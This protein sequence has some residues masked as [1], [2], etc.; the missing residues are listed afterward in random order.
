MFLFCIYFPIVCSFH[1]LNLSFSHAR[2]HVQLSV[3]NMVII[4]PCRA[5]SCLTAAHQTGFQMSGRGRRKKKG[6]THAQLLTCSTFPEQR[7]AQRLLL[8][9]QLHTNSALCWFHLIKPTRSL[10]LMDASRETFIF[11]N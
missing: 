5:D 9:V 1:D 3:E 7:R 6:K 11:L 2:L 4:P 10:R 8:A